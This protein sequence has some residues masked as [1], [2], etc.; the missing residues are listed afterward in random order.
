MELGGNASG[1]VR[2]WKR[3]PSLQKV[4]SVR[5]S[6]LHVGY[7]LD[8][9]EEGADEYVWPLSR[10]GSAAFTDLTRTTTLGR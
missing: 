9:P 2:H 7:E 4:S 5:L 10:V 6:V 8:R 3:R 1:R